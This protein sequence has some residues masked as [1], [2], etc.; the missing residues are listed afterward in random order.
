MSA[1]SWLGTLSIWRRVKWIV[2]GIYSLKVET[3]FFRWGRVTK[4]MD[5]HTSDLERLLDQRTLEL[6]T[7][8]ERFRNLIVRNADGIIIV[9]REGVISFIN[10]AAE[11]LFNQPASSLLGSVF[12]FPLVAGETTEIDILRSGGENA[13]GE[14]RVVETEWEGRPAF[15]ASLRDVTDRKRAEE[16]RAQLIREQ[17]ARA[18]A[19]EASRLK[20]EFLATV[21][22]ELRTPLNA[23]L[24]WAQLLHRGDLEGPS[25]TQALESIKR[26][27]K[28]QTQIIE[29]LLDVS[30][31]VS[32]KLHLDLQPDELAPIINAAIEVMRPAASAKSIH[33]PAPL[34]AQV[35][36]VMVDPYRMEQVISNLL[37]NAIKFTPSGGRVEIQLER[38]DSE[39]S[40]SVSDTG[41]GIS[42]EFLPHVFERFRQADGSSTRNYGGLGLG[43]AIVRHLVELQGGKIVAESKG[44]GEGATFRVILPL[45]D[46]GNRYDITV[47]HAEPAGSIVPDL[48]SISGIRVLVVDDDPDT[49]ELVSFILIQNGLEAKAVTCVA[50][51]LR[52]FI[53]WR[54]EI[55]VS[56]ISMPSEDGYMLIR[57]VRAM[58]AENGNQKSIP[59]IALTA[60]ARE[61]EQLR[62]LSAGYQVHIPKPIEPDNFL[63]IVA[64]LAKLI[65]RV[66]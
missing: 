24:G 61:Q 51:A 3:T 5:G 10:P 36:P 42:P 48:Q 38:L 33:L 45:A 7:S 57:Q 47:D 19:E 4:I 30:R 44:K 31:I 54:P 23:I 49:R 63:R 52:E 34:D 17:V 27:A 58:E 25:V 39:V 9:D 43:L 16:A 26:N 66:N 62:V 46:F 28:L 14:M 6:K 21:S 50:E 32:G 53:E 64:T 59:A 40:L 22:H 8:E 18:E 11:S 56:D 60:Y 29:D 20:D 35:G 12:G 55:L 41:S 65:R 37:S 15:L 1:A 2:S 13:V